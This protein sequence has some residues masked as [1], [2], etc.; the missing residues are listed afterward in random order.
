MPPQPLSSSR[1]WNQWQESHY[2]AHWCVPGMCHFLESCMPRI[3]KCPRHRRRG[4]VVWGWDPRRWS[5]IWPATTH[6]SSS[7]SALGPDYQKKEAELRIETVW[8]QLTDLRERN[9]LSIGKTFQLG[10][11]SSKSVGLSWEANF[12]ARRWFS[13]IGWNEISQTLRSNIPSL[14]IVAGT[15]I[16]LS[17]RVLQRYQCWR[18]DCLFGSSGKHQRCWYH[19]REQW[20]GWACWRCFCCWCPC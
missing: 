9:I 4:L 8:E 1:R 17:A 15:R 2:L 16:H 14:M 18:I 7:T 19:Q 13:W 20:A 12:D 6:Q 3:R 10:G 5:P 11:L